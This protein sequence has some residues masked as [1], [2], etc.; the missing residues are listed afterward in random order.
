MDISEFLRPGPEDPWLMVCLIC[1]IV[2]AGI[3]ALSAPFALKVG[4]SWPTIVAAGTSLVVSI[5]CITGFAYLSDPDREDQQP[6]FEA[7]LFDAY[8]A[9]GLDWT[10]VEEARDGERIA[11]LVYGGD[12]I[13]VKIRVDGDQLSI[14]GPDGRLLPTTTDT[15]ED[16]D[17]DT[18]ASR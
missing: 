16:A 14:T 7:A 17:T 5:M 18:D 15:D 9:T 2:F 13:A 1:G 11:T 8:G 3:F 4:S 12:T 10:T 6:R